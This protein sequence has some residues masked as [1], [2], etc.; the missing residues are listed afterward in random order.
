MFWLKYKDIMGDFIQLGK[1][2]CPLLLRYH[3][4]LSPY[5]ERMNLSLLRMRGISQKHLPASQA[6]EE[7]G[8]LPPTFLYVPEA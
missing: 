3:S 5:Q 8:V 2:T 6:G 1:G 7:D 4:V